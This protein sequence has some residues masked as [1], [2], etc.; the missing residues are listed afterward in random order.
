MKQKYCIQCNVLEM[1]AKVKI[2]IPFHLEIKATHLYL[3]I[4][5]SERGNEYQND[6]I[7]E[8]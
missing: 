2:K 7:S 4:L 8:K 5:L 6:R 3:K 1:N